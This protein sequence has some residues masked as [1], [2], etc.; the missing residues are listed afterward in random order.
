MVDAN[1][2]DVQSS[3][4]KIIMKSNS[5]WAMEHH[6]YMNPLTLIWQK[7][8]INTLSALKL[9]EFH[10]LAEIV[11]GQIMGSVRD[12]RIFSTLTFM[13]NFLRNIF[14]VCL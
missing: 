6:A 3:Y 1:L 4:F 12:E 2:L 9:N 11:V 14:W 5:T 8:N 10:K 7:L 13:K